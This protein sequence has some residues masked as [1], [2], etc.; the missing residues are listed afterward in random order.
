MPYQ[1]SDF[2]ETR[3]NLTYTQKLRSAESWLGLQ[4]DENKDE[5]SKIRYLFEP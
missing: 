1:I 2:G 3:L 4:W 5:F